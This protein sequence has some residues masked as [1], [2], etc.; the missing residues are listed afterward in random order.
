MNECL[1][2]KKDDILP[3]TIEKL[4]PII[5]SPDYDEKVLK[6]ASTAAFGLA[7]WVKAMVQYDEAMKIVKPKRAEAE[8]AKGE[9]AVA[10]AL[11]DA[12][13]DKLR[14]VEAEMAKLMAELE[15]TENRKKVL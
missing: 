5:E 3:A 10:Q 7:K 11:W 14:A 15:E 9:A 13:V 12:A 8:K 1:N 6:N 2:F 4:K